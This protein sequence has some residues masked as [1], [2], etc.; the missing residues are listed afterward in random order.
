MAKQAIT[1]EMH[2]VLKVRAGDVTLARRVTKLKS[3]LGKIAMPEILALLDDVVKR[4]ENGV[5]LEIVFPNAT[6]YVKTKITR[7][8]RRDRFRSMG[9]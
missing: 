3:D 2:E 6:A 7:E 9:L 8:E 1:K 5:P 4:L